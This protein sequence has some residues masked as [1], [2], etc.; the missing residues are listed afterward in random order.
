V[1]ALVLVR[2]APTVCLMTRSEAPHEPKN[3]ASPAG[4]PR[5]QGARQ[6]SALSLET[7][8]AFQA[9]IAA[10]TALDD[11]AFANT[12]P[13]V[14]DLIVAPVTARGSLQV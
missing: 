7:K 11:S 10:L 12:A 2:A 6:A 3:N 4:Q 14:R 9:E 13:F 5:M 1:I 8:K